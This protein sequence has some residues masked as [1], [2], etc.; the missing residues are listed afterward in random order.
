MVNDVDITD[1]DRVAAIMIRGSYID[2]LL[3]KTIA[4]DAEELA[5]QGLYAVKYGE[6]KIAYGE[7][8]Q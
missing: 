1:G 8:T 6:T 2:E 3:P 5:K 7:V 4:S